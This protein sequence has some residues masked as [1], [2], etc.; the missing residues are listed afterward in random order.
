MRRRIFVLPAH[1]EQTAQKRETQPTEKA[2]YC[3]TPSAQPEKAVFGLGDV[4]LGRWFSPVHQKYPCGEDVM[5]PLLGRERRQPDQRDT[6]NLSLQ[7]KLEKHAWIP[8]YS[9][10]NVP[11]VGTNVIHDERQE[12]TLGRSPTGAAHKK[13]RCFL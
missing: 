5:R 3:R 7:E 1:Q 9:L 13:Q 6:V 11:P 10:T 2:G 12:G 4:V 8:L